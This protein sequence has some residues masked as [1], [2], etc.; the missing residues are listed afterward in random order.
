MSVMDKIKSAKTGGSGSK[1]FPRTTGIFHDFKEGDNIVR[2]LGE[3]VEVRT[4]FIAPSKKTKSRGVCNA[5]AFTGDDRLPML[6]NCPDWDI[7]TE[8]WKEE[9]VCPVCRLGK[10]ARDGLS[11][12]D[13]SPEERKYFETLKSAAGGHHRY[14]WN[15][16][17][18]DNPNVIVKNEDGTT[19]ERVGIKIATLGKE[20][21]E[22]VKGI[23]EQ[24]GFDITDPDDGVDVKITRVNGNRV[25][26]SA[27]CMIEG[28]GLKVTPLTDEE[29]ALDLHDLRKICG[30]QPDV[31]KIIDNLHED[32]AEVL[33]INSDDEDTAVD[34]AIDD[35]VED[36]DKTVQEETKKKP[37]IPSKIK[38]KEK[39]AAEDP[40]EEDEDFMPDDD[41]VPF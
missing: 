28:K 3:Y 37:P 7:Q 23:F 24:V 29:R 13:L 1:K 11:N 14:K 20:A 41:D 40:E 18:R 9:R 35:A 34:S 19:E 12:P 33:S 31:D 25:S 39:P 26:Y 6:V 4:H 27:V 32:Y 36:E 30:K 15:V 16:I 21:F 10:I 17:D 2:F 38:G 22:A 5:D 8:S